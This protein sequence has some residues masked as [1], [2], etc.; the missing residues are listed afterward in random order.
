LKIFICR[1]NGIIENK[2]ETIMLAVRLQHS[3][4]EN[5]FQ[6]HQFCRVAEAAAA[7]IKRTAVS[8]REPP[9][10]LE[11]L[12]SFAYTDPESEIESLSNDLAMLTKNTL[13]HE[14]AL[15]IA[16]DRY[17]DGHSILFRNIE[18]ALKQTIELT[19]STV[20]RLNAFFSIHERAH[21]RAIRERPGSIDVDAIM[22]DARKTATLDILRVNAPYRWEI[23][24]ATV[25][26][27]LKSAMDISHTP[28]DEE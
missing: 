9:R 1:L 14:A 4:L 11:I 13:A 27:E 22:K 25:E 7:C 18:D 21:I 15:Q 6:K 2:A 5:L 16:Q 8:H 23:F 17:F 10:I 19:T 3:R 28:R 24:R 20:E 26:E 12:R